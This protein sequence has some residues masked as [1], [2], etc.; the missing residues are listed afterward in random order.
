M[1][2]FGILFLTRPDP[3]FVCSVHVIS[4]EQVHKIFV[5][6]TVS[7]QITSKTSFLVSDALLFGLF[8]CILLELHIRM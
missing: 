3:S 8:F 4:I 5:L 7:I 1:R 6:A 2:R